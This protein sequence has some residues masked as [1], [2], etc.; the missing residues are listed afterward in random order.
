MLQNQMTYQERYALGKSDNDVDYGIPAD[1]CCIAL[2]EPSQQLWV[3]LANQD[4]NSVNY[5]DLAAKD[6]ERKNW[7]DYLNWE[8]IEFRHL[9]NR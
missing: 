3:G 8:P 7:K 9:K 1:E 5:K 6:R 2:D 4:A